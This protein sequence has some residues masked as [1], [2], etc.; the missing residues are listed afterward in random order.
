MTNRELSQV[1]RKDLKEHGITSKDVS[2]RVR[3]ALYD[4]SVNITIKN[5]L[6]RETDVE[7]IPCALSSYSC[8]QV[9]SYHPSEE[10]LSGSWLL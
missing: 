4:T 3:D 6:I 1:I 9:R 7:S 5:P 10:L 2:V 8:M